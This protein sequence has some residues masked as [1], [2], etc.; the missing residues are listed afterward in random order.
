MY[1]RLGWSSLDGH[2]SMSCGDS[3]LCTRPFY[4]DIGDDT[5]T[6]SDHIGIG[7]LYICVI[8]IFPSVVPFVMIRHGVLV[9]LKI[10]VVNW[11]FKKYV[12]TL[13]DILDNIFD[14]H[15]V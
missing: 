14:P 5:I 1:P 8:F 3:T 4:G 11:Y 6:G 2:F 10:L 12:F 7:M 13:N 15:I 9:Y